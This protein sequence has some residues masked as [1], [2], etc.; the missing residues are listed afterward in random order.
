[1]RWLSRFN[2][3]WQ[4]V[5]PGGYRSR[6]T[7]SEKSASTRTAEWV[8]AWQQE[9]EVLLAARQRAEEVGVASIDPTAGAALRMLAAL[10][11]ARH[12]VELGT[13]TGVSSLWLLAGMHPSGVLTTIDSEPEHQRL[14]RQGLADAGVA[15]GRVRL[16]SGRALD[17]LPRLSD[18]AYDLVL[19]DTGA[20][21]AGDYLPAALRLLRTGGV[22]VFAGVLAGGRVA[23][24]A[25]RDADTT[26]TR[27]LLRTIRDHDR[28]LP[29]L[30]PIGSG[31]LAA[32]VH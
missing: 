25:A 13:G 4:T 15:S 20:A 16:I 23:D 17:V 10:V 24:P 11:Q 9:D 32:V 27:D 3:P 18:G 22:L 12:V 31:L 8:S 2:G 6:V 26:A 30:L 21:E 1:M 14:A 19:C 28:L 7:T 29:A 5:V